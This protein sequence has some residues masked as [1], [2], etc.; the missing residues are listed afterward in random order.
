MKDL[1]IG[2][3]DK[4]GWEH[5]QNWITS[6]ERSGFDGDIVLLTYRIDDATLRQCLQHPRMKVISCE[7]DSKG[8]PI[9]HN[10]YGRDTQ[11]HQMRFFHMWQYLKETEERY[12][13]VI[14]TDVRDVVFQTNPSIWLNKLETKPSVVAASEGLNY[15]DEHW[16][17]DNLLQGFGPYVYEDMKQTTINNVGTIAIR[18]DIAA[19]FAITLFML[20]ES[21]YI[22]ND[23]SGFNFLVR[24]PCLGPSTVHLT[25][26]VDGWAMQI[27]TFDDPARPEFFAKLQEARPV[28]QEDGMYN[29]IGKKFVMVHQYMRNPR[30]NEY[31][32]NKYGK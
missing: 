32:N 10:A 21:K 16:G 28:L 1:I 2:A 11:S 18:G 14:S 19:N 26:E 15:E 9:N 8:R 3:V 29:S 23:Q 12:G 17:K 27:G 7:H 22:P 25:T 31:F 4:Y 24:H 6:I 30:Y 5:I 20:G 13:Y